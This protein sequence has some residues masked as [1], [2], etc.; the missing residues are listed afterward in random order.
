MDFSFVFHYVSGYLFMSGF[1]TLSDQ[2][3]SFVNMMLRLGMQLIITG[4]ID[5]YTLLS[6]TC[7]TVIY[8]LKK[9]SEV[10][11]IGI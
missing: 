2:S 4:N 10:A 9:Y 8:R 6:L 7:S 3:F 1:F 5:L 11:I